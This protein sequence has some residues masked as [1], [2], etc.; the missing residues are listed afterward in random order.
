MHE[1]D[2][3]RIMYEGPDTEPSAGKDRA[4]SHTIASLHTHTAHTHTQHT[5]THTIASVFCLV[6]GEDR[7]SCVLWGQ[8]LPASAS[9]R[10][11]AVTVAAAVEPEQVEPGGRKFH[12][13]QEA[14]GMLAAWFAFAPVAFMRPRPPRPSSPSGSGPSWGIRGSRLA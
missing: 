8:A 11:D 12:G 3:R 2:E 13:F 4:H 5:H 7:A 9:G 6:E 1:G 10:L 14:L